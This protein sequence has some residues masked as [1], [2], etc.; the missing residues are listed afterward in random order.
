VFSTHVADCL[1]DGPVCW[2]HCW[3]NRVPS[4]HTAWQVRALCHGLLTCRPEDA[5]STLNPKL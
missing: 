4:T 3:V 1:D 5:R 2:T